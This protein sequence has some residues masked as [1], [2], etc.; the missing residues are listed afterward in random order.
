MGRLRKII[1]YV[2]ALI[3]LAVAPL[4]ILY[5]LGYIFSPTQQTL[6]AT[7]LISLSSEPSQ[8]QVWLNG[9]LLKEKTPVILRNLKPGPYTLRISLPQMHPWQRQV[10]VKPDRV[11]RFENILLF[12]LT[13][14]PEILSDFPITRMWHS[15]LGRNIV[16]L[17][18]EKASG[19]FL[20]DPE[21]REFR[22]LF[23]Q[24]PYG[25]T[26]V[27]EV[28]LHPSGE[29]AVAVLK[30]KEGLRPLLVNFLDPRETISL[31]ELFQEP[32]RQSHWGAPHKNS[33][34]YLQG[35][36]LRRLKADPDEQPFSLNLQEGVRGYAVQGRRL[37]VLD[38]QRR[39]LELTEKGKIRNILLSEPPKI[40]LIF[41]PEEGEHYSLFF[42]PRLFLF[43][44]LHE[45]L[46]L[47][48]S[49]KGKL[50]SNKLPYFLD[51]GVETLIPATAHSRALYRK[52]NEL[53]T[54]DFEREQ[55]E[56]FFESG[57][58]R[59]RIYKAREKLFPVA[60]FYDDRYL[61]FVEGNHVKVLDPEGE[62]NL[63]DLLEVS[64]EVPQVILDEKRGFLYFAEPAENRLS[65]IKLFEAEGVLPRLVDD[66]VSARS[67]SSP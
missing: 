55:E 28:L 1:F 16:V 50:I 4:T 22:P 58:A 46:A 48:L 41:G 30:E 8:A 39:F 51:E 20:F 66:F 23:S 38:G 27:R 33:L 2:F 59:R 5:A 32:F 35:N 12:P 31:G 52:G 11:F 9:E 63:M 7:G 60:W 67:E 40:R 34:F 13:F 18:G 14:H 65:R 57:P 21:R 26:A 29:R 6:V 36:T 53:W 3:Y 17:Q 45:A 10:E 64:K 19:L 44:P 61:L 56:G 25:E 47:F 43:T 24:S 54:V 15:P 49:D 37:F 42:L 62:G